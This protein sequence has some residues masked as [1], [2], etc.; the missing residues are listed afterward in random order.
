MD[1]LQFGKAD[2]E[3]LKTP[4]GTSEIFSIAARHGGTQGLS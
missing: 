2:A 4:M 1:G 3:V